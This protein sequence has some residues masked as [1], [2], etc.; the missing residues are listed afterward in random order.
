V[1][2]LE[3]FLADARLDAVGV[4]GYSPEDGTEAAELPD[5]VEEDEV[6]ARVERVASLA[7][8]L[9]SQRAQERVGEVVRVLVTELDVGLAE[10]QGPD[11]DGTTTLLPAVADGP[12]GFEPPAVGDVVLAEVVA[13]DGAD[14]TARLLP[15]P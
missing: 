9:V 15:S 7:D 8:E 3:A 10:H 11:V 12:A 13:S 14:L 4:F 5:Q 6:A 2:E 1:A